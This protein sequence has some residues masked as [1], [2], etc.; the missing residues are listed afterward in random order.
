MTNHGHKKLKWCLDMRKS[1]SVLEHGIFK[2]CDGSMAPFVTTNSAKQI[3][4]EGELEENE[5]F[6]IMVLFS[7]GNLTTNFISIL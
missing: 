6:Q 4:P 5:S 7:P 1:N 2:F 3:G